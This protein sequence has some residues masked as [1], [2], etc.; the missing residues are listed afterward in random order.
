M[1]QPAYVPWTSELNQSL[2]TGQLNPNQY[3]KALAAAAYGQVQANYEESG[4]AQE[5]NLKQQ[6]IDSRNADINAQKSIGNTQT[7]LSTGMGVAQ[8]GLGAY[9]AG[10]LGKA[11]VPVPAGEAPIPATGVGSATGQQVTGM[12]TTSAT[13]DIATEEGTRGAASTYGGPVAGIVA[14]EE[15]K[16]TLGA[17]TKGWGEKTWGE[18]AVSA[19][20]TTGF[21]P[22]TSIAAKIF[23]DDSPFGKVEAFL[24]RTEE[25]VMKPFDSLLGFKTADSGTVLCTELN[26]QGKLENEIYELEKIYIDKHITVAEYSGYR[27]LADPLVLLMKKSARFTNFLAPM[28]RAFSYEM[29]SRINPTVKGSRLG[30]FILFAGLPLCRLVFNIKSLGYKRVEA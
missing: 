22:T 16:N 12:S 5:R 13:G 7:L 10:L 6:E 20:G 4:R 19:P 9:K 29:A 15:I 26:R 1:A 24:G 2:A 21:D 30:K 17:P 8:I 14:G 25:T 28:I 18:R 3:N 27:I 11:A 23:G